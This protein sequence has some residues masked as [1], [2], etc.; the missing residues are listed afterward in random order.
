MSDEALSSSPPDPPKPKEPLQSGPMYIGMSN[1]RGVVMQIH[2]QRFQQALLAN[3]TGLAATAVWLASPDRPK[4]ALYAC[5]A[6]CFVATQLNRFWIRL[7]KDTVINLAFWSEQINGLVENL[8]VK[9]HL[10]PGAVI[11]RPVPKVKP[12]ELYRVLK[13]CSI[14]WSVTGL[15]ALKMVLDQIGGTQWAI[16]TW[17]LFLHWLV[18]S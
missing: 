5:V 13:G 12:N 10:L 7:I 17:H 16:G 18:S 3:L 1:T 8:G 11:Q 9:D 15:A 6:G 2:L 4:M 14:A